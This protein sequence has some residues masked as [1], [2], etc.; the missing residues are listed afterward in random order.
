VGEVEWNMRE[1]AKSWVST[2]VGSRGF[3]MVMDEATDELVFGLCARVGII[4]EEV[5]AVA[6]TIGATPAADRAGQLDQL[7]RA[8]EHIAT[9]V[10]AA[11]LLD[12]GR[13]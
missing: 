3:V 9:L 10:A 7:C 2:S 6:L 1:F 5:S 11:R 4:M 13:D 8:A 12:Q